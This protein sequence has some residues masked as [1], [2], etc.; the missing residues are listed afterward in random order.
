MK[1][2]ILSLVLV[3]VVLAAGTSASRADYWQHDDKGYYDPHHVHHH[4]AYH[5]HHRGY[6]D[7]NHIFIAVP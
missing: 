2:T 1:K 5:H 6:Y 4:W 7:E 3:A